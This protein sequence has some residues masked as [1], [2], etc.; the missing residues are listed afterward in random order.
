MSARQIY[1]LSVMGTP[2]GA[3]TSFDKAKAHYSQHTW[4]PV[5][6]Y[7]WTCDEAPHVTITMVLLS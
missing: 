5:N 4:R 1:V 2:I 7:T 6:S 3:G